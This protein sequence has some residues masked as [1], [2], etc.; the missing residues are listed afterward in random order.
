MINVFLKVLA[1][2]LVS[3]SLWAC[4]PEVPNETI[5][6]FVE[7]YAALEGDDATT[8]FVF[9][10]KLDKA[11]TS[12]V[13]F[14]YATQ[15]GT[16]IAG[17][18][19]MTTEG[20]LTIQSGT[21][22]AQVEVQVM[23]D[24]LLEA[25]ETFDLKISNVVGAQ[26]TGSIGEG[27]IRNDDTFAPISNDGY[28]TPLTY[29]NLTLVWHDEFDGSSLNESDW[30]YETGNSGWGNNELQYYR[31]GTNNATVENGKL[32]IEARQEGFGGANYT[33]ARITTEGKQSFQYGRIDIRAQLPQGQGIWP[34]LWMLGGNFRS[35]GWPMCGEIDIMELVGHE[36]STVHGTAHWDNS[37]SH[38]QFGGSTTLS[39]GTF[40]DEFHVFSVIWNGNS[41]QWYLDD[42]LYHTL[43]ITPSALSEFRDDFFFIFNIAVGGNWPG[44]PDATTTFPQRM[45]VDYV[46][47]FQ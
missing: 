43:D 3:I 13:T 26:V 18:D 45:Y 2:A 7:D 11:S 25:D 28:T 46:R 1:G 42:M 47:V 20:S 10:V 17:D 6:I 22:S 14:D 35:V 21:T 30:N 5:S 9:T 36:P 33:S 38:A 32:V 29:P 12:N 34:A 27:T 37:G 8:T 40:S 39:S 31:S 4:D 16:A 41:I 15:D 44:N 23:A 24:T 19:Y